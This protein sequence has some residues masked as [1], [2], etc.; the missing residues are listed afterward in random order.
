[1]LARNLGC[2]LI[3][4]SVKED[5]NVSSVFR[6]LATKCHQL[7]KQQYSTSLCQ[8]ALGQPTISAFSP[9]FAKS[10]G[11][12]ILRPAKKASMKKTMMKKCRIL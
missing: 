5:V 6:Y 8:P 1:M 2:R 9:T 11:T 4:T 12:I 7:M 10:N 3:R